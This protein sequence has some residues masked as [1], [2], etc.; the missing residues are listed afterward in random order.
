MLTG[1]RGSSARLL[2]TRQ[3]RGTVAPRSTQEANLEPHVPAIL[4]QHQ[5]DAVPKDLS[6][7]EQRGSLTAEPV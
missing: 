6:G 1:G 7:G 4:L 5:A 3:G 2:L